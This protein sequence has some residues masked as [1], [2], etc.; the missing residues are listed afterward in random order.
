M[1]DEKMEIKRQLKK[2]RGFVNLFS[3]T[4]TKLFK[5]N[6]LILF[7]A[8]LYYYIFPHNNW[9]KKGKK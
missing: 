6:L 7:P 1:Q 2:K 9:V 8:I 5:L 4:H 3:K